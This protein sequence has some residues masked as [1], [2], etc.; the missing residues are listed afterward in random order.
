MTRETPSEIRLVISVAFENSHGERAERFRIGTPVSYR[1]P[2]HEEH[3]PNNYR[4]WL[5]YSIT[6][7][8]RRTSRRELGTVC[9]VPEEVVGVAGVQCT[10]RPHVS[11]IASLE[12]TGDVRMAQGTIV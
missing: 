2:C 4:V 3:L 1:L 12:C 11:V 5:G 8:E 7:E 9:K 6:P 10:S